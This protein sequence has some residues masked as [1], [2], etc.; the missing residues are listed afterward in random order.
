M[1]IMVSAS[2]TE[3]SS[4][5]DPRFGRCQYFII[6]DTDNSDFEAIE[7]PNISSAG[8]A[9][10]DAVGIPPEAINVLVVIIMI[11]IGLM[12]AGYILNRDL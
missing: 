1:K 5:I 6:A 10:A 12:I 11:T 8:G 3:L 7:N 4:P 9:G 2:S